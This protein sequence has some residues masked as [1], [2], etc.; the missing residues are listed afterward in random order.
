[1]K[2]F[3]VNKETLLCVLLC[4]FLFFLNYSIAYVSRTGVSGNASRTEVSLEAMKQYKLGFCW[5]LIIMSS[6]SFVK[7]KNIDEKLKLINIEDTNSSF[8]YILVHRD[9]HPTVRYNLGHS[10]L[11]HSWKY[12]PLSHSQWPCFTTVLLFPTSCWLGALCALVEIA[13]LQ[14]LK[15]NSK[16]EAVCNFHPQWQWPFLPPPVFSQIPS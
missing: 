16:H 8:N 3:C 1:M 5:T 9:D 4:L 15:R 2:I 13:A 11:F 10:R 14:Y 7:N 6:L 12:I